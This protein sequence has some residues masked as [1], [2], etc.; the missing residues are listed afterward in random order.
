MPAGYTAGNLGHCRSCGQQVLWCTTAAGKRAPLNPDGTSHFSNCP[1]ASA[2]R[3][4]GAAAAAQPTDLRDYFPNGLRV[5]GQCISC[6]AGPDDQHLRRCIC[7]DG[8]WYTG[9]EARPF[10]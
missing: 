4:R 5:A 8:R 3:G 1:Q 9:P 7:F 2:W 6:G 10:A